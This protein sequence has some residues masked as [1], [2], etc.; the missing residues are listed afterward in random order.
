LTAADI[1]R[2]ADFATT[3]EGSA[4]ILTRMRNMR[5]LL[6]LFLP[7]TFFVSSTSSIGQT[8]PARDQ[9]GE[10]FNSTGATLTYKEVGR[11]RT[12]GRT[13]ITY[14]LFAS[15]LPKDQHYVLCVLNVGGAPQ[16]V[17][18]AYLNGD[19][20]VVNV[21]ADAE[22][23]VAEDP[24]NAKVFGGK[25]EPVQLALISD[26]DSLRAFTQ[27]IPFP[28]EETAGPCHLSLVETG[29]YYFGVL[30]RVAGLQP[31]EELS[32]EQHSENE[33]GTSTGK[34]DA[35]GAYNAGI[36][37]FVKGKRSGKARFAVAGKSCKIGIAFPWG[38]GSYQYQ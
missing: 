31:G 28:I 26:D 5:V 21:L 4:V 23:H 1:V 16:A 12:Q 38:E 25:G 15:G 34:A 17:A 8:V 18:D 13:V 35:T 29:P 24:I 32:I 6:Y 10:K 30:I 19:G 3:T 9:W 11:T 22:H 37:P 7:L 36:F 14:N 20:K 27:I 2:D 33:G